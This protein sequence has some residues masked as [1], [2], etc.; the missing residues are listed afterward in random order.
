MNSRR[1][2]RKQLW[3]FTTRADTLMGTT[4]CAV[5]A[6]H[7][8]AAWA[9]TKNPEI[10]PKFVEECRR[11]T[12]L[13]AE[14]AQIEKKGMADGHV[15]HASHISGEKLPVWVGNYVLMSYGE[16]AVMGVPA[17]DE[18]DFALRELKYGLP[19][20]QVI[21]VRNRL[22]RRSG[23]TRTSSTAAASTPAST[24]AW[25]SSSRS[26]PSPPT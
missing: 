5:A 17:H 22:P 23:T 24:T 4:F 2:K 12:V 7:P 10:S 1:Q 15:R 9:A 11:G 25:I 16:G 26:M 14:I 6:E 13:E 3:V 8:I 19:I 20:P 18:R 21:D